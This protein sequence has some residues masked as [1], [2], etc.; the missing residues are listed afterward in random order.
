MNQDHREA[1]SLNNVAR[2]VYRVLGV[3]VGLGSTVMGV[4]MIAEGHWRIVAV[5]CLLV[6]GPV[7]LL[8][9]LTGWNAV[10]AAARGV[11]PRRRLDR[12]PSREGDSDRN[13]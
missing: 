2:I 5:W 1:A 3:V 8:Y 10:M 13:L 4:W 6:V 11:S 9:G 12:N 7:L